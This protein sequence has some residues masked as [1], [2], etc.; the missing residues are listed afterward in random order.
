M[1][2]ISN[3]H[4]CLQTEAFKEYAYAMGQLQKCHYNRNKKNS[5]GLSKNRTRRL[6]RKSETHR[7]LIHSLQNSAVINE[8][9]TI[10]SL[11]DELSVSRSTILSILDDLLDQNLIFKRQIKNQKN[12]TINYYIASDELL[13]SYLE[14]V[15]GFLQR[16]RE[17][18]LHELYNQLMVNDRTLF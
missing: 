5:L 3:H 14:Y 16:V 12:H 18:R 4:K 7:W 6:I 1:E 8:G 15:L 11:M 13:E 17:L 9:A 2:T 10:S